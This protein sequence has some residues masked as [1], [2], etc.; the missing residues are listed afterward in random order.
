M[1]IWLNLWYNPK[2]IVFLI[3]VHQ[4]ASVHQFFFIRA[5][6]ISSPAALHTLAVAIWL[7]VEQF[8]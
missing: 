6:Q 8:F 2:E 1:S 4:A 5:F 3:Q 7:T